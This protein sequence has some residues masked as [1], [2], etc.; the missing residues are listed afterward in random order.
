MKRDF[1]D[2]WEGAHEQLRGCH[3]V[4]RNTHDLII[5][6]QPPIRED[7]NGI[8]KAV[9]IDELNNNNETIINK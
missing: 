6:R 2:L 7:K 8:G 1:A 3:C 5:A 4:A 9:R